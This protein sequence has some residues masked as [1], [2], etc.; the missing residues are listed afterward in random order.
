VTPETIAAFA[1]DHVATRDLKTDDFPHDLWAEMGKAGVLGYGLPAEYGGTE[2][3]LAEIMAA[4]EGFMRAG[5]NLG[6]VTAWQTHILAG[7]F[8]IAAHGTAAQTQELLPD[9]ATGKRT[10]CI[11]ISEPGAG[12]HPKRLSSTAR[13]EGE[14][15]VIDGAKAWLT[16]GPVADY[17]LF[18]AITGEDGGLK[19]FSLIGL[20]RDTPGVTQTDAGA[21]E[22]LKPCQHGGIEVK[23]ARVPAANMIGAEGAAFDIMAK[24]FRSF[25]DVVGLG[26]GI[27]GL[28][29]CA[30]MIA[31]AAPDLDE[32]AEERLGVLGG[33]VDV[34]R[35]IAREA[36]AVL[37]TGGDTGL[38]VPAKQILAEARDDLRAV[39]EIAGLGGNDAASLLADLDGMGTVAQAVQ[40]AKQRARGRQ[41]L[42]EGRN[43]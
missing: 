27:G 10:A 23:G 30:D 34:L 7:R 37:E 9:L 38:S 32:S 12:A 26:A 19:R 39:I 11:A 20:P 17:Y 35:L 33:R 4:A 22:F 36:V 1:R 25:E 6:I 40:R 16:N 18:L 28:L 42:E 31:G 13:R 15:F 41:L 43:A 24:G 21:V 8:F 29:A 5:R 3:S 2:A 14:A